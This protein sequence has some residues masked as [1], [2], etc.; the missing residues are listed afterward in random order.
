M[1]GRD[2]LGTCHE[3]D[4]LIMISDLIGRIPPQS[5]KIAESR[6]RKLDVIELFESCLEPVNAAILRAIMADS[7]IHANGFSRISFPA[8]KSSPVRI[9]LHVWPSAQDGG[10]LHDE[11][12]AHNH[13]WPFASRVLVGGLAHDILHVRPGQGPF[14][15]FHHVD[16]GDRYKLVL[17]GRVSLDLTGVQTT[18]AG[19]TYSMSPTTVH[20][21][22]P[23][24]GQYSATLVAELARLS[25]ATEVFSDANRHKSGQVR[26]QRLHVAEIAAELK[27]VIEAMRG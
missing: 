5:A 8:I 14:E 25:D 17:A 3:N 7:Y 11:P 26:P 19:M 22:V 15:H 20:R 4:S 16:L 18:A 12:D 10:S 24:G 21:V 2:S 9:R 27:R 13:K 23:Q 6:L 1:N